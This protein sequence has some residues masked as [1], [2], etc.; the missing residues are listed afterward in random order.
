MPIVSLTTLKSY[1]S[2]KK[3]PSEVE[4][5]DL[6]DTLSDAGGVPTTRTINTTSPL[7]GGGDLSADRTLSLP[8]ATLSA[9][10]YM[11][12]SQV[13]ALNST[14]RDDT[15]NQFNGL[16]AKILLIND[17]VLALED[18]EESY[19]KK[20][21]KVSSIKSSLKSYFDSLYCAKNGWE[22]PGVAWTYSSPTVIN[23]PSGATSIYS[24]GDRI[25]FVQTTNKYFNVVNI[26]D[27]QLTLYG[28]SDYSVANAAI[29]N[30]RF[31]KFLN[32]VGF[33]YW[34]NYLHGWSSSG[35]QPDLGNGTSLCRFNI[36]GRLLAF[37]SQLIMGSTTTYGTGS[38]YWALPMPVSANAGA[39]IATFM[40]YDASV[41]GRYTRFTNLQNN[42]V[43]ISA[44]WSS[45]DANVAANLSPTIPFTWTNGDIYR[46]SGQY[47]I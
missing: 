13:L 8:L 29:T 33:P 20:S 31:S 14:F 10:G 47:E 18:S 32:P 15:P 17:D 9:D 6:V 45:A 19:V 7:N 41:T 5:V 4:Y 40:L 44:L 37:N 16:S 12:S 34:F 22:D 27:A 26:S 38:Y 43:S 11:A 1:F 35:T 21:T 42:L 46:V 28:G 3:V 25:T 24:I 23:V 2:N 36:Y 39:S 30:P